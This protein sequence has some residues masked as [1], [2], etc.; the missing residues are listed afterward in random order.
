MAS[1]K[2]GTL[3][4]GVTNNL[5]SRV[6]Q[7]KHKINEGFTKNYNVDRLVYFETTYDIFAAIQREKQLK[8]WNRKWK[9]NLIEEMNP[10]WKDLYY[11][12]G[13]EDFEA[14]M[15]VD[16]MRNLFLSDFEGTINPRR[17]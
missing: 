4:I 7:H 3:Y 13:G 9:I 5:L 16:T 11:S 10:D 17:K 12:I 15:D 2:N 1:V 6:Y 14:N 8:K